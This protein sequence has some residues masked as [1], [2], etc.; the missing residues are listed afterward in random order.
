M[1]EPKR[2]VNSGGSRRRHAGVS[3]LGV[4]VGRFAAGLR[5]DRE[6]ISDH[7]DAVSGRTLH[8]VACLADT[9]GGRLLPL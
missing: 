5:E 9:S 7:V 8:F 2:I 4:L 6:A 1:T 3:P